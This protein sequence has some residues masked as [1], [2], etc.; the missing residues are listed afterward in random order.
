MDAQLSQTLQLSAWGDSIRL[1]EA[2][3]PKSIRFESVLTSIL[4]Q[5]IVQDKISTD[6]EIYVFTDEHALNLSD[7]DSLCVAA[8]LKTPSFS[9]LKSLHILE[10]FQV[11]SSNKHAPKLFLAMG[12][13]NQKDN[14]IL[15]QWDHSLTRLGFETSPW[16]EEVSQYL[17]LNH[18]GL[19]IVVQC[20]NG[21]FRM[22]STQA[23]RRSKESGVHN[24]LPRGF[25]AATLFFNHSAE[26]GP[27]FRAMLC[28]VENPYACLDKLQEIAHMI[29]DQTKDLPS[30]I[31]WQTGLS[32]RTFGCLKHLI[33]KISNHQAMPTFH[34]PDF[35]YG[36]HPSGSLMQFL[37]SAK[38]GSIFLDFSDMPKFLVISR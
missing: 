1:P 30:P 25:L 38:T 27:T 20:G 36:K 13:G 5:I 12:F 6:T 29:L 37:A 10:R 31:I 18:F 24:V 14:E 19:G 16:S 7:L 3:L 23:V 2:E 9:S 4:T 26:P 28:N 8:R 33:A 32:S 22:I 35:L 11:L 15:N 34:C 17:N 21:L